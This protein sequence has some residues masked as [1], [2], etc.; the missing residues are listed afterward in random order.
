MNLLGAKSFSCNVGQL[1]SRREPTYALFDTA[2]LSQ[3]IFFPSPHLSVDFFSVFAAVNSNGII[4]IFMTL[5]IN[6]KP[7]L[8]KM[9]LRGWGWGGRGENTRKLYQG[10][11]SRKGW[12]GGEK[13]KIKKKWTSRRSCRE[14]AACSFWWLGGNLSENSGKSFVTWDHFSLGR[15]HHR[16]SLWAHLSH[17]SHPLGLHLCMGK[18]N[19]LGASREW[20]SFCAHPE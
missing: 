1:F 8:H 18:L 15:S 11:W 3:Y 10:R 17:P 4:I 9:V 5:L 2:Y 13:A 14:E 6:V 20:P 16:I 7:F 19:G 12:S